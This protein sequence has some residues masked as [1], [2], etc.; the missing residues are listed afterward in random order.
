MA[1]VEYSDFVGL[2]SSSGEP[3]L[4]RAVLR[5]R[6][7]V[8]AFEQN[9]DETEVGTGVVTTGKRRP[10]RDRDSDGRSRQDLVKVVGRELGEHHRARR[11]FRVLEGTHLALTVAD[12]IGA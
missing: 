8:L 1:H 7:A 3:K 5:L 12:Q 9:D 10:W 6:R 4:N 2:Y 11:G